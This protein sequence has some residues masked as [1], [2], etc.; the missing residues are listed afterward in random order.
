MGVP[1]LVNRVKARYIA[2]YTVHSCNDVLINIS[3]IINT[4]MIY[5]VIIERVSFQAGKRF[6]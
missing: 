2:Y 3:S 5:L 6:S 1:H 4:S